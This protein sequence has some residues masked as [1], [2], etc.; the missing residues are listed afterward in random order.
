MVAHLD[1][2]FCY[3]DIGAAGNTCPDPAKLCVDQGQYA[4]DADCVADGPLTGEG[5]N[6]V[7][8][9]I[10]PGGDITFT[11][12]YYD[13]LLIE[14]GRE[15]QYR[16]PNATVYFKNDGGDYVQNL[17]TREEWFFGA[18]SPPAPTPTP[19]EC[20]VDV[21]TRCVCPYIVCLGG[22]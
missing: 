13:M 2:R 18:G 1:R 4:T 22:L 20:Q 9:V 15:F 6:M 12:T 21:S 14:E 8:F 7:P 10:K 17:N 19:G 3:R 11:D 5:Y 16:I